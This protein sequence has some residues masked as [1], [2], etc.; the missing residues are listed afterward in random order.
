VLRQLV[1]EGRV[2]TINAMLTERV[3][4]QHIVEGGGAYVMVV[5]DNQPQLLHDIHRLFQD[6][7]T[8]SEPMPA[9]ETVN[10]SACLKYDHLP[11]LTAPPSLLP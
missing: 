5:K 4:V 1:L 2:I 11:S 8:W 7:D 10:G 6:V 9:V 3:I